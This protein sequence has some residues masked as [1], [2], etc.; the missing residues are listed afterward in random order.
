MIV[1]EKEAKT[2]R[3]QESFGDGW[4]VPDGRLATP[5]SS[6]GVTAAIASPS[7][8]IGS[9]CMAWDWFD[10]ACTDGTTS[11]NHRR[12]YCAKARRP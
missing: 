4:T 6:S 5:V 10:P 11:P 1:T 8:C 12:G 9:G 7:F 2:K 3:C